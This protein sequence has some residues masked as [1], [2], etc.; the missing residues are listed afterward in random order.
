MGSCTSSVD[1]KKT[2]IIKNKNLDYDFFDF[3]FSCQNLSQLIN[4]NE[5]RIKCEFLE[6]DQNK[7]IKKKFLISKYLY[8]SPEGKITSMI[9]IK[10][11]Q[12][13]ILIEG[14][15][16]KNLNLKIKKS[17]KK[18][19]EILQ[20]FY[21]GEFFLKK[22][23]LK[24]QGIFNKENNNEINKQNEFE[25]LFSKNKFKV[26]FSE[27]F[28][29][30]FYLFLDIEDSEEDINSVYFLSGISHNEKGI[31]L[32]RGLSNGIGTN[33][34][35]IIQQ[36]IIPTVTYS[37]D[38]C[39]FKNFKIFYEGDYDKD[40]K[41]IEGVIYSEDIKK[42]DDIRFNISFYGICNDNI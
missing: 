12:E 17:E 29:F 25:I 6:K 36:Y 24:I 22:N 31:S 21:N 30:E 40:K 11:S 5:Y 7:K 20:I 16:H 19:D 27:N 39:D 23:S 10:N 35:L 9:P 41:I 28:F 32:W 37:K 15:I 2:Q 13:K 33:K 3:N 26:E 18:F 34:V 4:L 8:I 14:Q 38:K 42:E 1:N